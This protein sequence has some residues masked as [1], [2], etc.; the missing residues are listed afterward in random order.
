MKKAKCR[1]C[2]RIMENVEF[3]HADLCYDCSENE[4]DIKENIDN[5]IQRA[6][7][8]KDMEVSENGKQTRI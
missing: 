1:F 2:G 5:I 4:E 7:S 3:S 6:K 8:N